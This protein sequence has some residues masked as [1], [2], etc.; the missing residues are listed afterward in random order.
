[1]CV[2][3]YVSQC[4][5]WPPADRRGDDNRLELPSVEVFRTIPVQMLPGLFLITGINFTLHIIV[6]WYAIIRIEHSL[7]G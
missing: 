5:L 4:E 6:K 1:M 2:Y 3:Y 7:T